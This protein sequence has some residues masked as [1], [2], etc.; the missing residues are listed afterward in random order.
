M[1]KMVNRRNALPD[2]RDRY[3][4]TWAKMFGKTKYNSDKDNEKPTKR[5]RTKEPPPPPKTTAMAIDE[6]SFDF[7]DCNDYC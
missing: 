2:T 5:R 1:L 4:K 6:A 7:D 3:N